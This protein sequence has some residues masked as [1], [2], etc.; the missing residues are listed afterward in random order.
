LTAAALA[1]SAAAADVPE[2]VVHRHA[3]A[4][5]LAEED[6]RRRHAEQTTPE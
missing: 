2:R 3:K 1:T 4:R 5:A 6:Q